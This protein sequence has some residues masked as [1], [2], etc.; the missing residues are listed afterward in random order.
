MKTN[1]II[2]LLAIA[3]MSTISCS[4]RVDNFDPHDTVQVPEGI[5]GEDSIA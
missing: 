2:V 5:T 1:R 4:H 3:A